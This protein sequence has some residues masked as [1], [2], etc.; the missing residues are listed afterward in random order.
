[1]NLSKWDC[2]NKTCLSFQE[3]KN[4]IRLITPSLL[5]ASLSVHQNTVGL[6]STYPCASITPFLFKKGKRGKSRQ[7]GFNKCKRMEL[8]RSGKYK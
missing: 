8:I 6:S 5:R 3:D 7:K 1:M 2:H 4:G